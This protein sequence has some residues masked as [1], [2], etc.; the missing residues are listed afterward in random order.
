[1]A[2]H[3][4]QLDA[5]DIAYDDDDVIDG[6]SYEAV[7]LDRV[8]DAMAVIG[9][10]T[11]PNGANMPVRGQRVVFERAP[12]LLTLDTDTVRV[13]ARAEDK[14][15]SYW[16]VTL[17]PLYRVPV[18]PVPAGMPDSIRNA[19]PLVRMTWG[20]GG[21]TFRVDFEYPCN[22]ASFVVAGDN[23]Q[24]DA[25]AQDGVNNYAD[26]EIVAAN[27]W[28]SPMSA[29]PTSPQPLVLFGFGDVPLYGPTRLRP[30]SR[31]LLVGTDT[32]GA[33]C[34]VTFQGALGNVTLH[35]PA[36]NESMRRVPVPAGAQLVTV[37]VSAGNVAVGEELAFS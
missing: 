5:D 28:V 27:A 21:V 20:G 9:A 8:F 11:A 14:R 34:T 33:T 16:Q 36:A 18:G 24:L 25:R 35:L 37:L 3:R 26:A 15:V 32:A 29:P 4:L 2:R 22:G 1:M 6:G 17:S 12:G 7:G 19:A 23:I 10:G 31:A 13:L 30:F